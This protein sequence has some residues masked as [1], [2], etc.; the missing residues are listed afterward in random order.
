MAA[1]QF[2]MI[3][4][5]HMCYFQLWGICPIPIEN[6]TNRRRQIILQIISTVYIT[7]FIINVCIV[8]TYYMSI[9]Y[10]D[11]LFGFI[12]DIFKY[13]GVT[14]SCFFI[15]V[16][17]YWKRQHQRKF[18]EQMFAINNNYYGQ[19][20]G[21]PRTPTRLAM[22]RQYWILFYGFH[23][24]ILFTEYTLS[25]ITFSDKQSFNFWAVYFVLCMLC[26]MRHLQFILYVDTLD[27]QIQR[28]QLELTKIVDSTE[29]KLTVNHRM[30][31]YVSRQ[32][33]WA[34]RYY[35]IVYEMSM[36]VNEAFGWSQLANF[37]H[38]FVQLLCDL[39]WV[40]WRYYNED[41]FYFFR[42]RKIFIDLIQI[43]VYMDF[44]ADYSFNVVPTLLIIVLVFQSSNRCHLR[45]GQHIFGLIF[46][47][48]LV[49]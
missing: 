4:Y 31:E 29:T 39:Y 28:L 40:Y 37:L 38:S 43:K 16:E 41:N 19:V 1:L 13:I 35:G 34:Q 47:K 18:W 48:L 46:V 45:V 44:F 24:L 11:D 49:Y 20:Y 14:I 15:L 12:N 33:R 36:N 10:T 30:Q 23:G 2:Q 5:L 25:P 6:G 42:E 3:F 27:T 7:F 32:L 9:F 26:R 8:S 17:S 21:L 22:H